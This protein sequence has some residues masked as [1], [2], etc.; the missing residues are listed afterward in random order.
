MTVIAHVDHGKTTLTDA[1]L[2]KCGLIKEEKAGETLLTD[3]MQEEQDR[4]I[5]IKA[6]S[7]S[8][9]HT[10]SSTAGL[11]ED[12]QKVYLIHLIDSP[13]HID[14]SSEVTGALRVTDGAL[15]IVDFVDGV[16]GQTE[17]VLRQALSEGVKPC[18]LINKLDK[19]FD[20]MYEP[21]EFFNRSEAIIRH[22]NE[23]ISNFVEEDDESFFIN[24]LKGNCAFGSGYFGWGVTIT[25]VAAKLAE[26]AGVEVDQ[27]AKILWGDWFYD[28]EAKSF[29]N[30]PRGSGKNQTRGF[31]K[32]IIQPIMNLH[33]AI[34]E[35]N[36][37]MI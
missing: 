32:F 15:V 29:A 31:N 19:G 26:K 5:T 17:T 25:G 34:N 28:E 35:G 1:L 14:F 36:K 8:M 37:D 33:R 16:C 24:P 4:G 11:P 21:E 20:L 9:V 13:G 6:T 10:L 2:A 7:I 23:V 27:M 18:L 3:N 22:V 12:Q 30:S